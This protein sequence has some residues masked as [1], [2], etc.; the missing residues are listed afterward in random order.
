MFKSDTG[1]EG[2]FKYLVM[3]SLASIFILTGLAF[4][5]MCVV[6]AGQLVK[7]KSEGDKR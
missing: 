4:A 7:G 5:A 2:A 1:L 3:S 6:L